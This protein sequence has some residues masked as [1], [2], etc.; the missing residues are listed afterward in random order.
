MTDQAFHA[1]HFINRELSWLAFNERVLDEAARDLFGVVA[2]GA[3]KVQ[4]PATYSL[5]DAADAHRDLESRGTTGSLVL[6][7]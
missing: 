3:V 1:E 2:S 6:I 7:P 4:A 5:A